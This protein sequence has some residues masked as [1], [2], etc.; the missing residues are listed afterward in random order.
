[1]RPIQAI[2]DSYGLTWRH[3]GTRGFTIE[4]TSNGDEIHNLHEER[5]HQDDEGGH[6]SKILLSKCLGWL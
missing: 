4:G 2:D 6:L 5:D 1:M 3:A